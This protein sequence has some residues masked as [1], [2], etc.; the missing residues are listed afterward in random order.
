MAQPPYDPYGGY[1]QQHDPYAVPQPQ[2]YAQP[3]PVQH[4]YYG[5][6]SAAQST[7]GMAT[8]SMVL[9]L[10]GIFFCGFTSVLAIIFGH[11]AHGQIKRTGEG[12]SGMA[13]AGLVLGYIVAVG[14]IIFWIFYIGLWAAIVGSSGTS[15]TY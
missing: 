3:A 9:G 1:G 12:G 4:N 5:G 8:A 10:V 2:P 11:V 6:P 15:T 7:N 13:T 14:W